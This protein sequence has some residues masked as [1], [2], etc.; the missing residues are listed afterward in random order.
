MLFHKNGNHE[1]SSP[2]Q[3]KKTKN[4]KLITYAKNREKEVLSEIRVEKNSRERR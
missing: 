4:Y 2:K 3:N 1:Y